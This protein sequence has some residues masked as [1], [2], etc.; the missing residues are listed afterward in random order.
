MSMLPRRAPC[1][2]TCSALLAAWPACGGGSDSNEPQAQAGSAGAAGDAS[3]DSSQGG[4]DA[5]SEDASKQDQVT[6]SEA[7]DVVQ[8][9][10]DECLS[11]QK[12]CVNHDT[13]KACADTATGHT[14][15]EQDCTAGSG[16]VAGECVVGQCSDECNLGDASGGKTCELFDLAGSAWKQPDPAGSL[17]DRA[18]AYQ[19]WLRR[20]SMVEGGV[21]SAT[22]ADPG[23]WK[24]VTYMDGIGDSA[25]WTGTYLA[26]EALRLKATGDADARAN[27][28]KVVDTLHVWF[29]VEGDPG[30]LSRW[31]QPAGKVQSVTVGDLNCANPGTSTHCNVD[32][33]GKKWDFLGHISR[34]QYQG[35]MM[36][37]GLAYEA[38]GEA[39]EPTRAIIRE[40]VV[41]LLQ[42][43]MK[44]RDV[45]M[46]VTYNG[47][48][49]PA[50]TVT[51]R[52]VV[53]VSKEMKNGAVQFTLSGTTAAQLQEAEMWGFQEFTPDLA[54]IVKQIPGLG[55]VP[56]IPRASSAIMLASFFRLGM[57]VTEG[58]V[59]YE[60][61]NTDIK[62]YY[63]THSGTGGNITNW[64]DTMAMYGDTNKCG[65]SYFG[66][67]I[68]MEPMYNL[69]R[70]EDDAQLSDRIHNDVFKNKMWPLFAKTK[71]SFFSYIYAGTVPGVDGSVP[72]IATEQLSQFPPPPRVR[73]A[74]DLTQDPKY[75]PHEPNCTDQCNHDT[76]VD[77][78]ERR[79][80][81]FIWQRDPWGLV[82]NG[83]P[84]A[85]QPG[86][87]YLTA[88]WM[89]RVHGF[90]PEDSSGKCLVWH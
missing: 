55:W 57:L 23:T 32:Y 44:D 79:V 53:L 24:Q 47:T 71:N 89:A 76:A 27:I 65:E 37:F 66:H 63:T 28:K 5:A 49:L 38:L 13:V 46:Q 17:H 3:V 56:A 18:R 45:K 10:I 20:D 43:L 6:P 30:V 33:D 72:T 61:I 7:G 62:T 81:D 59:G 70:L 77:I 15:T 41:E 1:F 8:E 84:S 74:V 68:S 78:K 35:V 16:C 82:D 9:K 36:G 42:E 22:Y 2:A 48:S 58:I 4:S 75:L 54:D 25:I 50:T 80:G 39:D 40:D 86:V 87:D 67:N 12:L 85:T 60:Q 31:A 29:N 73:V 83:N 88:Y 21:G 26:S 69:S 52:Y 14:W 19:M 34:D 64:I 51:M 11:G 90:I